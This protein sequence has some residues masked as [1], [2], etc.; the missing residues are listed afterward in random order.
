[1]ARIFTHVG[2]GMGT[3][4]VI[5]HIALWFY[6]QLNAE[7]IST[8]K[9]MFLVL[10]YCKETIPKI[11]NKYSQ[12]SNCAATVPIS[13]FRCQWAIYIFPQFI[14]LLCCRK[15]C[16]PILG[17]YKSLKTHECGN[18]D[19]GR[20]EFPEKEYINGIFVAVRKQI[21]CESLLKFCPV[22]HRLKTGKCVSHFGLE[23]PSLCTVQ[24]WW[25]LFLCTHQL[26]AN[27]SCRQCTMNLGGGSRPLTNQHSFAFWKQNFHWRKHIT[28]S[29]YSEAKLMQWTSSLTIGKTTA[30]EKKSA[31]FKMVL[32]LSW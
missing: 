25:T 13:T 18:W 7:L 12:K 6:I 1:M 30:K 15:I 17:I 19:W 3:V 29:T 31:N 23:V 28:V 10:K 27:K 9:L 16:G 5:P 26:Q 32:L 2:T 22:L 4:L 21:S 24:T 20:M 8:W 14:C 11:R